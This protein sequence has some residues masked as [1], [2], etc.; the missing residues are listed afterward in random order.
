MAMV[1]PGRSSP[2]YGLIVCIFLLVVSVIVAVFLGLQLGKARDAAS[3]AQQ[4]LALFISPDE[5]N[6]PDVRTLQATATSDTTIYG[7]LY[8]QIRDLKF[9]IHGR[10]GNSV[11]VPQLIG[12]GGT[13]NQALTQSNIFQNPELGKLSLL[14]LV[15]KLKSEA[16]LAQNQVQALQS[17]LADNQQQFTSAKGSFTD[18]LNAINTK[19]QDAQQRIT[20]LTNQLNQ[21]NNQLASITAQ[22]QQQISDQQQKYVSELQQE[23]VQTQ[24]LQQEL[25]S[26]NGVIDQM[27]EQISQYRSPAQGVNAILSQADGKILNISTVDGNVYINLG[28]ADHVTVGL[29]FAVYSPDLGVAS[30]ENSGG[31]GSI[32]VTQTTDH[33]S[34]A[35]ITH[36]DDG[37]EIF[38]GDLIANP[39]YHKDL[40]KKYHF[41]IYGDFD[42]NG[43]GVPTARGREQIVRMVED[44][45]GV[46]DNDLSSQTDFLI[47]GSPPSS[48]TIDTNGA[49]TEQT[50]AIDQMQTES[51]QEYS[52]LTEE[53]ESLSVPI[54]NA[55]R[56]LAMIGY[57]INP[58]NSD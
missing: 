37:K 10:A 56:F 9:A 20:D 49:A 41:V 34:V 4:N 3:T 25:S 29:T 14:D 54:L 27:R 38:P 24:Q 51:Q 48:P 44:W 52:K 16:D 18:D 46:V 55:N 21:S 26:D 40:T 2:P 36:L 11:S 47:L 22:M 43:N 53:A 33:A 8:D 57:Y 13:I 12:P 42:M 31:K 28:S 17:Q 45:G 23:V 1:K 32:V 5:L 19:L 58:L 39:V 6:S 15:I 50:N 30:G 35:R 7:Q